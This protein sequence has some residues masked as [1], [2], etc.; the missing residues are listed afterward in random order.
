M[1]FV[2]VDLDFV[3]IRRWRILLR[4][5]TAFLKDNESP[6]KFNEVVSIRLTP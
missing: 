5:M 2:I 1:S 6:G 3:E 4:P